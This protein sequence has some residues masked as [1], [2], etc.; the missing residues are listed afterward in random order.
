[1][2]IQEAYKKITS[3]EELKKKAIEALKAGKTEEF[4]KE[5]GIDIT[6]EQIKDYIQALKSGELSKEELDLAAGGCSNVTCDI[7]FSIYTVIV[8]CTASIYDSINEN[9]GRKYRDCELV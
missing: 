3:S 6:V 7:F 2:T 9:D 8:G 1:M 5:Q 4:L